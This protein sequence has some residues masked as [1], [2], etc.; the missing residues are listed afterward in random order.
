VGHHAWLF[1]FAIAALRGLSC[2]TDTP[3]EGANGP[4]QRTSDCKGDLICPQG[5]CVAPDASDTQKIPDATA[6]E[7]QDASDSGGFDASRAD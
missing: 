3:P 5:F 6:T 2:G 1:V 7:G 4:C